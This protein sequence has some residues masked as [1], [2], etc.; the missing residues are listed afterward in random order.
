M[1]VRSVSGG[2]G[3]LGHPGRWEDAHQNRRDEEKLDVCSVG[4][5]ALGVVADCSSE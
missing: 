5:G 4:E 1:A 2:A 3:E